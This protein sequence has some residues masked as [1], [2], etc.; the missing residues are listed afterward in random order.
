MP[1]DNDADGFDRRN[2][3]KYLGVAGAAGLA[4]CS[5]NTEPTETGTNPSSETNPGEQETTDPSKREVGGTYTEAIGSDAKALN[6]IHQSDTTSSRFIEPTLDGTYRF[7]DIGEP[8][9]LWVEELTDKDK[10]VW[11]YKLRDNLRWSDPYGQ[12]TAEDWVYYIQNIHQ[13]EENWAGSVQSSGWHI[14]DEPIHVEKTGKL[15]FKVELPSPQPGWPSNSATWAAYTLPKELI[16]PYV[17]EKDTEGLQQD[18]ELNSLSYTGNLGPYK[19]DTWERESHYIATRN[20]EWYLREVDDVPDYFKNAPYF[21]KYRLDIITEDSTRLAALRN[22][23]LTF[24]E[25]VPAP[26]VEQFKQM[27]HLKFRFPPNPYCGVAWYNQRANGWGPMQIKEVRQALG[28]AVNKQAIADNIYRGFPEVA[29]TFQPAW[30][31]WYNDSEVWTVGTG[32]RYSHE[33]AR[34]RLKDALPSGYGYDGDTLKNPDGEDVTLKMIYRAGSDTNQTMAEYFKQEYANIGI[35]VELLNPVPF[36]TLQNK[37]MVNGGSFNGGDREE[38]TSE[39]EWDIMYG[40]SPNAYPINPDSS[41]V[42]WRKE[43]GFNFMGYH[44]EADVGGLYDKAKSA[45]SDQERVDAFSKVF[46][47]LSEEQPVNWLNFDVYKNAYQDN[48]MGMPAEGEYDYLE[49]WDDYAWY[50]E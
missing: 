31:K 38:S 19:F 43:G 44:P 4:G 1:S 5:E 25:D 33:K 34:S 35:N 41:D 49:S 24:F 23:E 28:F 16:K 21:E 13:G 30:S 14:D 39:N 11:E 48:Y 42:F 50:V 29:H 47:A 8:S 26:K 20:D 36:N 37:Y 15:S 17:D 27:D 2:L 10:Q 45:T 12:M 18:E 32:D 9:Y 6:F 46:T 40:V 3:L 22:D 7:K